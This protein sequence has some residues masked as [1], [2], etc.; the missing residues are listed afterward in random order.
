[1]ENDSIDVDPLRA[2]LPIENL[3][4]NLFLDPDLSAKT[5]FARPSDPSLVFRN[6][7]TSLLGANNSTMSPNI[8]GDSSPVADGNNAT[9]EQQNVLLENDDESETLLPQVRRQRFKLLIKLENLVNLRLLGETSS[10]S[11]W[12]LNEETIF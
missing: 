5:R 4:K 1:M 12:L 10:W 3:N 11:F 2:I 8:S 7:T 9:Q 6:V